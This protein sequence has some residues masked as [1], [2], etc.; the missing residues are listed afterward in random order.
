MTGSS[1]TQKR[2]PSG[3]KM[4]ACRR[5]RARERRAL[6]GVT[7]GALEGEWG[8]VAHSIDVPHFCAPTMTNVGS[9][10]GSSSPSPRP[11]VGVQHPSER[12]RLADVDDLAGVRPDQHVER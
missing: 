8:K 2:I 1:P 7:T 5:V 12:V 4:S 3:H 11:G 10:M 9:G 6:P